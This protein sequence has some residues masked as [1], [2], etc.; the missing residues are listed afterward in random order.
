MESLLAHLTSLSPSS[1]YLTLVGVLLLCGLGVPI[2]EDIS[3][4]SAGYLAHLGVVNVHK[5][6]LAC[7]LAVLAGDVFAFALG[8][9]AGRRL[10]GWSAFQRY[11]TPRKQRRARAYFR[12]FG[13]RV[14]FVGRFLPG[15]RFSIFFSA[16]TLHVR[17]SAFLLYDSLAALLSVPA[18]V[19]LAYFFGAKID[20]VVAWSRRSEY[21][22][23]VLAG[24]V[25]TFFAIK[26]W[27]LRR[28]RAAEA[29]SVSPPHGRGPGVP[30]ERQAL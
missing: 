5:V 13:N 24:A 9:Y 20:M 23:L 2:P 30:P 6:L 4:I 7:F 27:R 3:L 14:I 15:L 28:C 16:G 21:G 11:F 10:L 25:V 29:A 12:K 18:L 26:T 17:P 19:Y 8:H 1:V 22:L